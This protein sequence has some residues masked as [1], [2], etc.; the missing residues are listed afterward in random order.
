[1]EEDLAAP[2]PVPTLSR[3]EDTGTGT[4]RDT[5]VVSGTSTVANTQ[6]TSKTDPDETDPGETEPG[7]T[8]PDEDD[9][10]TLVDTLSE[11]G[12]TLVGADDDTK[13]GTG[14][15]KA[16]KDT[17]P[18]RS[19]EDIAR[20]IDSLGSTADDAGAAFPQKPRPLGT[21]AAEDITV[22]MA[23]TTTTTDGEIGTPYTAGPLN[24]PDAARADVP[25]TGLAR[26][27]TLGEDGTETLTDSRRVRPPS[28]RRPAPPGPPPGFPLPPVPGGLFQSAGGVRDESFALL[29]ADTSPMQSGRGPGRAYPRGGSSVDELVSGMHGLSMGAGQRVEPIIRFLTT[30]GQVNGP[31]SGLDFRVAGWE[32][33][34]AVLS[35][36]P[37][38]F[39]LFTGPVVP[40]ALP[41]QLAAAPVTAP[42]AGRRPPFFLVADLTPRGIPIVTPQGRQYLSP[43]QFADHLTKDQLLS[44]TD[45]DIPIV[46]VIPDGGAHG[47]EL[48]RIIAARTGKGVWSSDLPVTLRPGADGASQWIVQHRRSSNSRLGQ[49]LYSGPSDTAT[50]I[51][52]TSRD[53]S[54]YSTTRNMSGPPLSDLALA[55]YTVVDSRGQIVGRASHTDR[56]LAHGEGE[57][58]ITAMSHWKTAVYWTVTTQSNGRFVPVGA[59]RTLPW[60][61]VGSTDNPYFFGAYGI[62]GSVS[63]VDKNQTEHSVSGTTLGGIIR[64]RSSFS[65]KS[66]VVLAVCHAGATL[67]HPSGGTA[68][69]LAQ[70]VADVL[71]V[72]VHAPTGTMAT[73]LAFARDGTWVTVHPRN[74][75]TALP[76]GPPPGMPLPP[77]PGVRRPARPGPPPGVPLPPA[78]PGPPPGFPPPPPPGGPFQSA[79][80]MGNESFGPFQDGL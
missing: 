20:W 22:A 73:N 32:R 3:P 23:T 6:A 21:V 28:T 55:S 63:L 44:S 74:T 7:E 45:P 19:R 37:D 13:P 60:K 2:S 35:P 59:V 29:D 40:G 48:P 4:P 11:S 14:P 68:A 5:A 65:G 66:S 76:P 71:Q 49:W 25:P 17:A 62:P 78:P 27:N 24:A 16:P 36:N 58:R 18:L 42:W 9:A 50:Q 33:P 67:A 57:S 1:P 79:G 26:A 30:T 46:L 64:R 53:V 80:E 10:V 69:S 56:D 43:H 52:A 34:G 61:S 8:E 75:A 77:V 47:L 41:Y 39:V 31:V 72:A 54:V 15:T 12:D 51:A 70:E 38:G